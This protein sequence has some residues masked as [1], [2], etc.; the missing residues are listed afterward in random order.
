[1]TGIFIMIKK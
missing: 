1:M